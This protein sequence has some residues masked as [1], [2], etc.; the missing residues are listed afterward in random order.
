MSTNIRTITPLDAIA[1]LR[2]VEMK[3][4]LKWSPRLELWC[5]EAPTGD[6]GTHFDTVATLWDYSDSAAEAVRLVH[7]KWVALGRPGWPVELEIEIGDDEPERLAVADA[8]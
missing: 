5:C 7:L 8:R 4:E 6:V 3:G 1:W 2:L